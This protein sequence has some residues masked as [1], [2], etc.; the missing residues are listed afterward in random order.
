MNCAGLFAQSA[1][2]LDLYKKGRELQAEENY[3]QASQ[4]YLEVVNANPAFSQVWFNLAECSYKLGEFNLAAQYL[5][6][7]EK[8]EK[9]NSKIQ[10]LKGMIYLALGEIDEGK[11]IFTDILKSYPND[12]DAHFGLAEIELY[13]GRFSG[14]EQQYLEALKRQNSNRKAL[15]SMALVCAENKK[16][17]QAET[18]LNQALSYYSGDA[19]VHYLCSV[20]YYMHSDFKTAE[21]HARIAVEINGNLEKSY[22]LLSSI[23]FLQGEYNQVIDLCDFIIIRNRKNTAAWYLKG[24]TYSKLGDTTNAISNWSTGL[25]IQ[26]D[27]ELMRN[28]MEIEIRANLPLSDSRRSRWAEYH[29]FNAR[30]YASRYDGSSAVYEYQR[31]LLLDPMNYE[32]RSAYASLL[33]LNGMY[34]LYLDQLNFIKENNGA[35]LK[36]KSKT[37]LEDKIEAYES[38][39]TNTL[40]KKWGI[41]PFYL[42]K[43]R[44]KIAVFYEE[45]PSSFIHADSNRLCARAAADIFSGVAVTSVKTQVTPV[46]GFGEAFNNARMNGFDY[47]IILSLSE[48]Q[49]DLTLNSTLY[50]GRTGLEITKNSFYGTGNNRFST[51]LRRFRNSV[52]E[53]LPVRGKIL[54]RDGK[55]VVVDLGKAERITDGAEF[56]IIKKGQIRT[57][58]SEPGLLYKDKDVLGTLVITKA[59]EEI[60][61]ASIQNHGFYDRIN[62]DDEVVLVSLPEQASDTAIDTAPAA[63]E[64]GASIKGDEGKSLVEEIKQS[65]SHPAI[66]DLLH[67]IY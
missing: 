20:I 59:G 64:N 30:Q 63:N 15:L 34:E 36:G 58:D 7:A 67:D 46:S 4:Y 66:I 57:A 53:I 12:I 54:K 52:L 47:F 49:D 9:K 1:S 14:A 19:E 2:V 42:D 28:L 21:K 37:D 26:S 22:E 5:E 27:D 31:A 61:E 17:Q 35:S 23:L 62:I 25:E 3:F 16:F 65:V 55:T 48:G 45:S 38:L 44:W 40:G 51:I 10:N 13:E 50:S 18:F 24:L 56:K 33:E 29:L 43:T 11:K 8:Y 32:A 6:N 41:E 39:L 60:S